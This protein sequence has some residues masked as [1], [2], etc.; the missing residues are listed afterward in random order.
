MPLCLIQ[1]L[2]GTIHRITDSLSVAVPDVSREM[3]YGVPLS[4]RKEVREGRCAWHSSSVAADE[5]MRIDDVTAMCTQWRERGLF[6]FIEI[7]GSLRGAEAEVQRLAHM[8]D[9]LVI[10]GTSLG[11]EAWGL[12]S[13]QL[14]QLTRKVGLRVRVDEEALWPALAQLALQ[15]GEPSFIFIEEIEM[16]VA[17]TRGVQ[18]ILRRHPLSKGSARIIPLISSVS[19]GGVELLDL[20]SLDA[21]VIES[22]RPFFGGAAVAEGEGR[23][24]FGRSLWQMVV[25]MIAERCSAASLCSCEGV[26][27]KYRQELIQS[28][29]DLGLAVM[30]EKSQDAL[31][32]LEKILATVD[33]EVVF[34]GE[35]MAALKESIDAMIAEAREA[36]P[37]RLLALR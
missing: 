6:S 4:C 8:A 5:P 37:K 9:W 24:L 25:G 3:P 11:V 34:D 27:L 23:P 36:A 1:S 30:R 31:P 15:L 32:R 7:R 35:K 19:R 13:A 21:F 22:A 17:A 10:D 2:P 14:R 29:Y 16:G 12:S 26:P 33:Q 28:V 18:D 20:P